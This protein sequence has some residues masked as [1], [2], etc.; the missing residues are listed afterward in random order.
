MY[1]RPIRYQRILLKLSG[2]ILGGNQTFCLE[3]ANL[4]VQEIAALHRQKLQIGLVIG[5]GNIIRGSIISKSGIDR[6]L[7]DAMGMMATTINSLLLQALL[8][9][10]KVPTRVLTARAIEGAGE[11]YQREKCLEYLDSGNIV[12]FAGG[13]GHPYFTTDTAAALRAVEISAECLFKATKVD[14]VY[15]QDPVQHPEARRFDFLTYNDVLTGQYHV[16]DFTAISFCME[17]Q[18]P[19]RVFDLMGKG[20]LMRI[21]QGEN[22]GTLIAATKPA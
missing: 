13:T 17:N 11:F 5:G 10:E 14:G 12:I 16:M 6:A 21:V 7:G 20:N 2:E 3:T 8:A 9:H 1:N 22:I 19:I 18:I 4:I 15:D